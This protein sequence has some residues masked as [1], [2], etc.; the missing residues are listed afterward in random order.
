MRNDQCGTLHLGD[1]VGDGIGLPAARHAEQRLLTETPAKALCELV[2]GLGLVASGAV[3]GD[4]LKVSHGLP[5]D[6]CG[7]SDARR[8]L[9]EQ[10][11]ESPRRGT[12]TTLFGAKRLARQGGPTAA[13]SAPGLGCG[14]PARATA[15]T[16][17]SRRLVTVGAFL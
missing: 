6:A 9:P 16:T 17:A 4:E 3:I 15:A 13:G 10:T 14:D 7:M 2:N 1:H 5:A 8:I 11:S 12:P